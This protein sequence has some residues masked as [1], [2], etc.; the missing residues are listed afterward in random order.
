MTSQIGQT[1]LEI[2]QRVISYPGNTCRNATQ[3]R[4]KSQSNADPSLA[5][6]IDEISLLCRRV[7][8]DRWVLSR[9]FDYIAPGLLLIGP[10]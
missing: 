10:L 7:I 1:L 6:S 2:K 3:A 4:Q 5:A 9:N 8:H